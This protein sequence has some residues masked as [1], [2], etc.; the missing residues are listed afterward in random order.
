[1]KNIGILRCAHL[2]EICTGASCF[3]AFFRRTDTFA[4]Y[5]EDAVL[6][7]FMACNGCREERPQEPE[8]D[9]GILEKLDRLQEEG[10]EVM[11][12]GACRFLENHTECPRIE[13]ITRMIQERGIEIVKGTHRE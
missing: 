2:N 10:V 6:K 13:K 9:V 4:R 7:A 11:H 3:N 1:M 8:E 12:V 5:G